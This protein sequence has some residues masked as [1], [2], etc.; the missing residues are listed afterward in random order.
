MHRMLRR[1]HA[2]F[3]VFDRTGETDRQLLDRF[4]GGDQDAFAALVGRHAR[5]VLSA[6]RHVLADPADVDDAFQATFLVLIRKA[7]DLAP[8]DPAPHNGLGEILR[9]NKD[10]EGAIVAFHKAIELDPK[11]TA[12]HYNIGLVLSAKGDMRGAIAA[13]RLG[14]FERYVDEIYR[15]MWSE[16][17]K[18]DDPAVLRAALLESGF[19]ADRFGEPPDRAR[20]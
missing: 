12:A 4:L 14:V 19:D 17:R 15:H 2:S 13:Q 3:G 8:K 10:Y 20:M 18:L 11:Y 16:P 6:C 5:T 9:V 7:R 1:L